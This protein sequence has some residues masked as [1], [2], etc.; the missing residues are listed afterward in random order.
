M[1]YIHIT[2]KQ[3]FKGYAQSCGSLLFSFFF[4]YFFFGGGAIVVYSD[5]H[6]IHIEQWRRL[7]QIQ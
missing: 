1:E 5:T 3:G 7:V 6:L 4:L 2:D